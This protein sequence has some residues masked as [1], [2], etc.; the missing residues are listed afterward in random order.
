MSHMFKNN[1][2]T[3]KKDN[4]GVKNKYISLLKKFIK[5]KPFFVRLT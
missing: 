1:N 3:G 4:V 2:K 5:K